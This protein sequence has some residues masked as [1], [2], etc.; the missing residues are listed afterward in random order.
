MSV[1]EED[2]LDPMEEDRDMNENMKVRDAKASRAIKRH[3]ATI[4]DFNEKDHNNRKGESFQGEEDVDKRFSLIDGAESRESQMSEQADCPIEP[5]NLSSERED[6]TGYFDGD[7][8]VFRRNNGEEEDA[9]LEN[10]DEKEDRD[11]HPA[12]KEGKSGYAATK[13]ESNFDDQLTKEEAYEQLVPLLSSDQETVLQALGRYGAIVKREKKQKTKNSAS[14]KA[15]NMITELCNICMMKF[16]D[17]SNIYDYNREKMQN[18]LRQSDEQ[19]SKKRKSWFNVDQD[20]S[21][22]ENDES[23][24]KRAKTIGPTINNQPKNEVTWE[25]KGNEDNL[26][27][28]PYT[29]QQMM[30]W[31]KAGYFVGSMAVDVRIISDTESSDKIES[32]EDTVND[33]LDDLE[34]S[35]NEESA[36]KKVDSSN[37]Q[38]FRSDE[39][40]FKTYLS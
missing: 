34:D 38:W 1:D 32:K 7:T 20:N 31:T 25:Y 6:G 27:H 35:D 19:E 13:K 18:F 26:I 11:Q 28:G 39:I 40:N 22:D 2:A 5:F 10:L 23:L 14:L 17:G 37:Q 30:E 3:A 4:G 33:L 9:W 29:T 24:A 8:Y 21:K 12:S 15:L 36:T 16:D